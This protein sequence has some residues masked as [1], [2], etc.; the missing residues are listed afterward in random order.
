[1]AVRLLVSVALVVGLVLSVSLQYFPLTRTTV[2][3]GAGRAVFTRNC[4]SCHATAVGERS[5]GPNLFGIG[6]AAA[7]RVAGKSAEEYIWES[8]I[9]PDAYL[10]FVSPVAMP[11]NTVT[12]LSQGEQRNLLAYLMTLGG[13]V[14]YRR[15]LALVGQAQLMT[16][17]SQ[18]TVDVRTVEAGKDLYVNYFKCVDCHPLWYYAGHDSKGPSLLAAGGLDVDYVRRSIREPSDFIAPG[19]EEWIVRAATGDVYA[20]RVFEQTPGSYKMITALHE[21]FGAIAV[22]TG[23]DGTRNDDLPLARASEVSAMP[24]YDMTDEQLDQIVAFIKSLPA[25]RP[26]WMVRAELK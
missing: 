21:C 19:F 23:D 17:T 7:S 10:D 1:M 24:E 18:T 26:G 16:R 15:L 8:M 25:V 9:R 11:D 3:P 12:G 22:R 2:D 4:A 13:E 5:L 20:G 14:N 6:A